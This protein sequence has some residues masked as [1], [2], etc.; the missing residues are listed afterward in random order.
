MLIVAAFLGLLLLFSTA[1]AGRSIPD[2]VDLDL[3]V[4]ALRQ[5]E[6]W[7]GRSR[8][9]AGERG[10]WQ[11]TPAVWS[12]FSDARPFQYADSRSPGAVEIQRTVASVYVLWIRRRLIEGNMRLTPYNFALVWSAGWDCVF[13]HRPHS[14]SK[15]KRDYAK[16]AVNIYEAQKIKVSHSNSTR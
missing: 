10:Y 16:R 12:Q 6:N 13:H 15:A 7:D 2:D 8:G 14:P 4:S 9:S 1:L 3:M 5:V 11:I